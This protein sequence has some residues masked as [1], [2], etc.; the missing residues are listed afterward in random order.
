MTIKTRRGEVSSP[1]EVQE[2]PLLPGDLRVSF[3][4]LNTTEIYAK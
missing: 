4:S 2:I 3:I 1:E